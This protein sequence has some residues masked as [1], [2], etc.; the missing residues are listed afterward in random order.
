M[1]INKLNE[2]LI[3]T[4]NLLNTRD[5][6]DTLSQMILDVNEIN[7]TNEKI[8]RIRKYPQLCPFLKLLYDPQ[9]T[10]GVT[11]VQLQKYRSKCKYINLKSTTDIVELLTKLYTRDFSGD[12]AKE[13]IINFMRQYDQH[14]ELILKI[15]NKD[16]Q[17][18]LG[19]QQ[20]NHAFPGLIMFF[21]VALANN[22]ESGQ[23]YFEKNQTIPWYI[24]RKYDGIRCVVKV[25]HGKA[26]AYSRTGNRL[27]AMR[28]LECLVEQY[29]QNNSFVLDGEVCS[30]DVDGNENFT[31][32]VSQAKRKFVAMENF[33]FYVFDMLTETEFDSGVSKTILSERLG[34]LKLF[35][36]QIISVPFHQSIKIVQQIVYTESILK[37]QQQVSTTW[38]GLMLRMNTTY[39]GKRSNHIL[40]LKNF[41]TEEY[42]VINY[43]VGP[44]RQIVGSREITV[45]TLKSVQIIHK[46]NEVSV[47]SGFSFEERAKFYENPNDI[48]GKVISVR[49]FTES[50]DS[51]GKISL[52]FP[53]FVAIHGIKRKL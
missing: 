15:M 26:V 20:L 42:K 47:G 40:K 23:K 5:L 29:S 46:G 48:V 24:S 51:T 53:T 16:L 27:N 7:S 19:I 11:S 37:E 4:D 12:Q 50:Q 28:P 18:R 45:N 10:T 43:E 8:N 32:A 33:R 9:Q 21:S 44:M 49:Y 34:N 30:V 13:H 35:F 2:N 39:Q 22:F 38:E 14:R 1:N 3:D 6:L 36:S 17:I 52:R 31:D 25:S 41:Q